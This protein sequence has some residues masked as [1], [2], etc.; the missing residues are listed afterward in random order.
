MPRSSVSFVVTLRTSFHRVCDQ[1]DAWDWDCPHISFGKNTGPP[2]T[3]TTTT[4][5][6]NMAHVY[7]CNAMLDHHELQN[8]DQHLRILS[9]VFS[10][11]CVSLNGLC[12]VIMSLN[13]WMSE[14][15]QD[16]ES[17]IVFTTGPHGL[18]YNTNTPQHTIQVCLSKS[19]RNYWIFKFLFSPPTESQHV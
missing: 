12:F 15:K 13:G 4:A 16:P 18:L 7:C 17:N 2:F 14:G 10:L 6:K 3:S 19:Q 5:E 8:T 1:S 11:T 9:F